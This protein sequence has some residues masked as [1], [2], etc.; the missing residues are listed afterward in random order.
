MSLET[1]VLQNEGIMKLS[2]TKHMKLSKKTTHSYTLLAGNASINPQ[3]KFR[4][5]QW[6]ALPTKPRNCNVHKDSSFDSFANIFMTYI[7]TTTLS[8]TVFR[9]KVWK[10]Y[11]HDLFSLWDMSK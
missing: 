8:K 3:R 4:P 10:C 6:K 5:L 7:E 1:N 9:T 2:V 11:M